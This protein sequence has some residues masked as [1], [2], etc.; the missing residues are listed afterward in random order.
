[1]EPNYLYPSNIDPAR[2]EPEVRS[3]PCLNMSA[4]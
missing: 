4:T 1:M 3:V 2:V